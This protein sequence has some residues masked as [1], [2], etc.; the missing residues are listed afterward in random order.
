MKY[1]YR[2]T[3]IN[4]I[5][6]ILEY[7]ITHWASPNANPKYVPIGNN[8]IIARRNNTI[9]YT[10][11]GNEI[12][13]G[14]YIPFYFYARMPM[15]YNIQ[16]GYGVKKVDADDIVYLIVDI[17]D[18]IN[19][20]NRNYIFSDAHAISQI[21][22]FYEKDM[23]NQLDDILDIDAIQCKT[24]ADDYVKKERKQAEFLVEGDISFESIKFLCCHSEGIKQRLQDIGAQMK[25]IVA[26]ELAY[27]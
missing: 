3:H 12:T 24:W 13:L 9:K 1:L 19:D 17:Y 16:H 14:D 26:P 2:M 5:P 23:I 6:H 7:G 15:L 10:I 8:I 21:A 18:I 20:P 22:S 11:K 27:Y 4:N 25:I